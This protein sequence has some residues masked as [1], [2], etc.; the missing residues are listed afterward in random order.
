[1]EQTSRWSETSINKECVS[2]ISTLLPNRF[3]YF[4]KW[5]SYSDEDVALILAC[6]IATTA[7]QL[8]FNR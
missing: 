8:N 4:K 2:R 6:H 5:V 7:K 1:M 3:I